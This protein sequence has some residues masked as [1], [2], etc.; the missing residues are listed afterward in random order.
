MKLSIGCASTV[1]FVMALVCGLLWSS[2]AC[3]SAVAYQAEKAK[4]G[5]A[6]TLS[7]AELDQLV[8]PIA[9]YPDAL[10][11][12][13]LM[14]STY[15]LEV[16]EAQ[17]WAKKNEKLAGDSLAKALEEQTWD[18]SVKSLVNFPQVLT[19]MN[20]NIDW[21]TKLGDAFLAQQDQLMQTVQNLRKKA[22]E[23]GNLKSNEQQDVKVETED[24]TQVIVIE[25]KSPD[26]IYVPTYDPVVVYG[27]WPYPA[28]P[29]YYY[30]PP[31]YVPGTALVSFGVGVACGLAW[32]YAWGGCNW[33]H[34]HCHV[35]IDVNRNVNRNTNINRNNINANVR[36]GQWQHDSSHRKGVSYL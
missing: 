16:I 8:A 11:A 1:Q 9:L 3:T 13:V 24:N 12:Q 23:A 10:V 28:Y 29:P 30:Y 15:P 14:A 32:G 2:L 18:P 17:R 27:T 6:A 34:G 19:Q 7:Q 20:D 4:D 33:G 22:E 5:A 31:S 36:N 25:S 21:M 35:D 26:V